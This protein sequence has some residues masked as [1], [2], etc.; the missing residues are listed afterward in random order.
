M[1][2][3]IASGPPQSGPSENGADMLL[4]IFKVARLLERAATQSEKSRLSNAFSEKHKSHDS[5]YCDR[6]R[7]L[8][9][10]GE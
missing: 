7:D 6:K 10:R 5:R 2:K 1:K 3:H 4:R 9:E 8:N